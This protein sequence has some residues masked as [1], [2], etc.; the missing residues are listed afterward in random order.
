M[1]AMQAAHAGL[2]GGAPAVH[3]AVVGV[4]ILGPVALLTPH[5]LSAPHSPDEHGAHVHALRSALAPPDLGRAGLAAG[6]LSATAL[7]PTQ[8]ASRENWLPRAPVLTAAQRALLPLAV[9]SS[10]AAAVAAPSPSGA[11]A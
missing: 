6:S 1:L 5:R 11:A 4:R 2:G 7:D 10:A 8:V 9:V 3:H